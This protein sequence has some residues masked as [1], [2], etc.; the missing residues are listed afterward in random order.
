MSRFSE[1][2]KSPARGWI[3]LTQSTKHKRLQIPPSTRPA[4]N[5]LCEK[6]TFLSQYL[7]LFIERPNW[8]LD[9]CND[10]KPQ[11]SRVKTFEVLGCFFVNLKSIQNGYK[12]GY[13]KFIH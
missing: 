2:R 5:I 12:P 6:S 13:K 8:S 1:Q 4:N 7:R 9:L 10:H 3:D 11:L